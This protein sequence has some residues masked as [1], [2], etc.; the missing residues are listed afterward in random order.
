M[1]GVGE[2][3]SRVKKDIKSR[4]FLFSNVWAKRNFTIVQNLKHIMFGSNDY[5]VADQRSIEL[6]KIR[7]KLNCEKTDQRA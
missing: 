2:L 7:N 4:K 6:C 3:M 5:S 1:G